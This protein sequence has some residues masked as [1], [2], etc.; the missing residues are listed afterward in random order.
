MRSAYRL[1]RGDGADPV[2]RRAKPDP[3]I[4][5][6][7]RVIGK[8]PGGY[9]GNLLKPRFRELGSGGDLVSTADGCIY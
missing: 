9:Q 5:R 1:A 4:L 6:S 7:S 2:Y 8:L 3:T